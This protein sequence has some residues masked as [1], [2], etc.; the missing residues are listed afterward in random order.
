MRI[1]L[2]LAIWPPVLSPWQV[3]GHLIHWHTHTTQCC[4]DT[5]TQP[6]I[7]KPQSH[8]EGSVLATNWDPI[9]VCTDPPSRPTCILTNSSVSK[10]SCLCAIR[11][12]DTRSVRCQAQRHPLSRRFGTVLQLERIPRR[13]YYSSLG[14]KVGYITMHGY[15]KLTCVCDIKF[16][17]RAC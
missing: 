9:H 6:T 13:N 16:A 14:A 5:L 10:S 8:T 17:A 7:H 3:T 1:V 12:V 15:I 11:Y 4:T 2:G